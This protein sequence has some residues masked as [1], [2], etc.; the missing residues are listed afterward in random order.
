MRRVALALMI[1]LLAA[2]CGKGA[3]PADQQ[4]AGPDSVGMALAQYSPAIFDSIQWKGD[5]AQINRGAVV[6]TFSCRKCH[7]ETGAGDA[8][9]VV[10]NDTIVPP[11]FHTTGWRFLSDSEGLRKYIYAGNDKKM[12]HWGIEGLKARDVDAVT[13]Y[14][15]KVLTAPKPSPD[16]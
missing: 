9:F 4:A 16:A 7:G 10:E 2:A 3:A 12:P 14:I 6:W 5:S 1:P 8:K 13:G 15:I 11:D